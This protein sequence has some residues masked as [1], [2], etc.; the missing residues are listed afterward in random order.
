MQS[1]AQPARNVRR[2]R[3]PGNF[4]WLKELNS[5]D[6]AK[7]LSGLLTR[8]RT[9]MNNNKWSSVTEWVQEWQ[10]TAN[11]KADSQVAQGVREGQ[12]ELARGDS[13]EWDS[14]RKELGL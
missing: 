10:A 7:F 9:A 14:L 2:M 1:T 11:I 12:A 13:V 4:A 6:Q 3:I 5:Q 8:V